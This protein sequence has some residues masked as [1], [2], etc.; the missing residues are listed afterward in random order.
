[1]YNLKLILL[2]DELILF[3]PKGPTIKQLINSMYFE[4]RLRR[5]LACSF[6]EFNKLMRT[7]YL[8]NVYDL[9]WLSRFHLFTWGWHRSPKKTSYTKQL[10]HAKKVLSEEEQNKIAWREHKQLRRDRSKSCLSHSSYKK[11]AKKQAHKKHRAWL[12]TNIAADNYE[13]LMENRLDIYQDP[14]M[15]D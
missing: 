5:V 2:I 12:R 14:W 7:Q 13:K 1:M 8:P 6:F 3:L 10:Y 11:F 15:W 9:D 4:G